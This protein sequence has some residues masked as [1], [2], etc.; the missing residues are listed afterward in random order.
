MAEAPR[1][2]PSGGTDGGGT[3]RPG[4]GTYTVQGGGSA[5]ARPKRAP[6]EPPAPRPP[7]GESYYAESRPSPRG[8][9]IL[10]LAACGLAFVVLMH[11]IVDSYGPSQPP[12]AQPA[13]RA[14]PE[15]R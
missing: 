1:P 8:V 2:G 10:V 9:V 6:R 13:P 12:A 7:R 14:S 5:N 11:F 3:R 15:A 4:G